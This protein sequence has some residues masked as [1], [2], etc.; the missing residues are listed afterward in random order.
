MVITLNNLQIWQFYLM[1]KLVGAHQQLH[2]LGPQ[3]LDTYGG[4]KSAYSL[5]KIRTSYSGYAIRVRRS[6]DNTSQD[7]GLNQMAP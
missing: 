3:L 6:N 7:I 2:P 5:R 1:V 4:A